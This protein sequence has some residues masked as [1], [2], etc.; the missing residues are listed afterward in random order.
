MVRLVV[1]LANVGSV[2]SGGLKAGQFV[3]C[4]S[5]TGKSLAGANSKVRVRFPSLGEVALDYA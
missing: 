4:G 3:T 5:W 1:W 2:W